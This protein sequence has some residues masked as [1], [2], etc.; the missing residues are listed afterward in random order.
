M[1]EI[2]RKRTV[3]CIT[4]LPSETARHDFVTPL[5][6]GHFDHSYAQR[7][8]QIARQQYLPEAYLQALATAMG[9]DGGEP[10]IPVADRIEQNTEPLPVIDASVLSPQASA[11]ARSVQEQP[12]PRRWLLSLSLYLVGI[13]MAALALAV[14]QASG[15]WSQFFTSSFAPMGAPWYVLLYGLLGGCISCIM[16]LGR[17]SRPTIPGFVM[18]TW[19]ARPFLGMVLAALAYLLLSSGLFSI[20]V[21]PAQ[22]FAICSVIGAIAGLCEGWLF[23]RRR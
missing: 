22:R 13:L 6:E 14:L 15:Y 11:S 2:Y 1:Q 10:V 19:F 9:L 23:F 16:A 18:L 17:S 21:V 5:L 20:S 12:T 8:L 3:Q 4:Y 7:L